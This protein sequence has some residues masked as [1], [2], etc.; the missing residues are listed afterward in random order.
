MTIQ[1]ATS[2][3]VEGNIPTEQLVLYFNVPVGQPIAVG[4][5][6]DSIRVL[7]ELIA[8]HL[9]VCPIPALAA[10]AQAFGV[11]DVEVKLSGHVATLSYEVEAGLRLQTSIDVELL[12]C[13]R[14]QATAALDFLDS[15]AYPFSTR[16]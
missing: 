13:L 1:T 7:L 12:R 5:R 11:R 6:A 14:D 2:V 10:T 3:Q 4:L 9:A 16:Q 8:Q 15:T